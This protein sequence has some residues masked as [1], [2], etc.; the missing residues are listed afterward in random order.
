M[1]R[2]W[3]ILIF[4]IVVTFFVAS[5]FVVKKVQAPLN[6]SQLTTDNLQQ[7]F[8]NKQDVVNNI[9]P[10]VISG[11]EK[12]L[13]QTVDPIDNALARITKKPFGKHIT[14][15]TSPVQPERFQGYHTGADLEIIAEEQNVD[16][17]VKALCDGKL[18]VA[19]YASGYGGVAVESCVLD[20]QSVA[21]IYGHIRLSSIKVKVGDQLK[22]G[23]FLAKLGKGYGSE[24]DGERKHLHLGIH[25]GANINVLG[26]VAAKSQLSA[27]LDPIIY[28]H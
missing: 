2:L 8:N 6:D 26:Y 23:D 1:R 3:R 24:T 15:K 28:L 20:K 25:R 27:W 11:Q 4:F 5:F 9:Q 18:L 16:V 12:T 10:P 17:P 21:V 22:A 13:S 7:E 14:P 19:R